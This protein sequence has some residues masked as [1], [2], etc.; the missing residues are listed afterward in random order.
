MFFQRLIGV[1]LEGGIRFMGDY[2]PID[3]GKCTRCIENSI[4]FFCTAL[5]R[6]IFNH[7]VTGV[8]LI[9]P[10]DKVAFYDPDTHSGSVLNGDDKY[11]SKCDFKPGEGYNIEDYMEPIGSGMGCL[12]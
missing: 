1:M 12:R 10:L 7:Q 3:C 9:E 2:I 8:Y 5:G 11:D 4:G 6:Y